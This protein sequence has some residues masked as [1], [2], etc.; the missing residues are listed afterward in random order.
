MEARFKIDRKYLS[1]L[2]L[3]VSEEGRK[4]KAEKIYQQLK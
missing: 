2:G 3:Y 1:I 4:E